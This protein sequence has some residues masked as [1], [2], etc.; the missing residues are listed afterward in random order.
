MT[1][2]ETI[3]TLEMI[4]EPTIEYLKNLGYE[5]SVGTWDEKLVIYLRSNVKF[6]PDL[7]F[8]SNDVFDMR[9]ENGE[10]TLQTTSYGTLLG[11]ELKQY[12]DGITNW[13]NAV[14]A[15]NSFQATKDAFLKNAD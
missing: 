1:R 6:L 10:W 3:K 9:Q 2:Q 8:H 5:V 11:D 7:Y 12:L 13:A 15:L 4:V 14:H